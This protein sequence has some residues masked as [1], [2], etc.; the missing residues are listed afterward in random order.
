VWMIAP[1]LIPPFSE[2]RVDQTEPEI[3]DITEITEQLNATDDN[4]TYIERNM[5]YI[6]PD[7]YR[8]F[9]R[10]TDTL[11]EIKTDLSKMKKEVSGLNNT[12]TT[13][14]SIESMN[15]RIDPIEHQIKEK[16]D[17]YYADILDYG[18]KGIVA[19]IVLFMCIVAIPYLQY[20]R[21]KLYGLIGHGGEKKYARDRFIRF[22]YVAMVFGFI[23]LITGLI[24]VTLKI[25]LI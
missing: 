10:L 20:R 3:T 18:L 14:E 17:K 9:S 21:G 11:E 12:T 5:D 15:N 7:D 1:E 4:L 23:I 16:K 22:L 25:V 2:D 8:S 19:G 6:D 13:I 24:L